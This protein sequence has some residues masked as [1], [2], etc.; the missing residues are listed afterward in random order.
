MTDRRAFL[1]GAGAALAAPT[2]ASCSAAQRV[3]A[4]GVPVSRFD[5]DSTA[6]EV[7]EGLDLS[8]KLAVVTGCTSGIGFETMRVLAM[9]GAH[10]VGTSRSIERAEEACRSVIGT[11]SPVQLDLGDFD[12]VVRCA[13]DILSLRSP[14][15][16]LILNA[17]YRGGG[18]ER[19]LINGVEKHFVINHLGHFILVNR[20]LARLYVSVQGRVV[21]VASR[22]AYRDA[23]EEG[24]LFDDLAMQRD[25]S[26]SM[27]YG[28]SKLANAL[29]SMKLAE[30]LRGTRMTSNAL[31]P[32]VISTE[33]SR[34]LNAFTRFIWNAYVSVNGKTV[35]QGA[36]TTCYV[37]TAPALGNVS[38]KYFEDCNAVTI[39]GQGHMQDM[40]MA[41]RLLDKTVEL[42]ADWLVEFREP[43]AEDFRPASGATD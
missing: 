25:Y 38:G 17:G 11:T 14:V 31:H 23:P 10:V 37:A 20:L 29:F 43:R 41:D 8:G 6:E 15:D 19:Q 7:T 40:T 27:A 24:I 28:H 34:N 33:L 32:G 4:S 13:N 36:A 42:T 30:L 12:S 18:N 3:P 16:M 21:T 22:T 5:K 2:L 26:D 1:V 9:R 39:E 35:G